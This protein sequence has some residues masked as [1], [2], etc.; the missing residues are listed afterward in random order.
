MNTLITIIQIIL[1]PAHLSVYITI[2]TI[3][4]SSYS[5]CKYLSQEYKVTISEIILFVNVFPKLNSGTV[6]LQQMMQSLQILFHVGFLNSQGCFP[7]N[8]TLQFDT[9]DTT[10]VFSEFC[11]LLSHHIQ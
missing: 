6:C 2:I 9:K 1:P 10:S 7:V 5:Q 4:R 11:V 8:R 3:K